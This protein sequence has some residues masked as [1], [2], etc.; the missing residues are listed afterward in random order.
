M[1]HALIAFLRGEGVLSKGRVDAAGVRDALLAFLA[2]SPAD[3]VLI[4]LEDLW[5]EE[6]WQNIPGT[7][8]E[9]PNWRRKLRLSMEDIERSGEVARVLRMVDSARRFRPRR[10]G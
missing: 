7:M 3:F 8:R 4:N 2:R 10:R 6:A 1:K 9:H 5:L